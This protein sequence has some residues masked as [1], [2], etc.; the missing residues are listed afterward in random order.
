[1]ST[2]KLKRVD[3]RNWYCNL[4]GHIALQFSRNIAAHSNKNLNYTDSESP[5]AE[6]SAVV[7]SAVEKVV[8]EKVV[9]DSVAGDSAVGDSAAVKVRGIQHHIYRRHHPQLCI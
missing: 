1:M 2:K 7:G 8:V 3:L 6:D 5:K 9:E 4:M